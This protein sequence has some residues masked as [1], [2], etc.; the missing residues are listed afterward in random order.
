MG[1]KEGPFADDSGESETSETASAINRLRPTT[2]L[3]N[4]VTAAKISVTMKTRWVGVLILLLVC[5]DSSTHLL[6]SK[7]APA[8]YRIKTVVL[9][10]GHGGHDPGCHGSTAHEKHIALGIVLKLGKIL[11]AHYPDVKVIYTRD[12]DVFVELNERAAIANRNDADLFISVH[13]NSASSPS[14]YGTE[15]WVM[16]AKS[17][18]ANLEVAK[19]ENS[20]I[21]LEEDYAEKYEYDPNSPVGQIIFSVYQNAYLEQSLKLANKIETQ[22]KTVNN[23]SSRGVKRAGFIV[24]YR[25]YMPSVLIESGFLTNKSDESYLTSEK[26]QQEMAQSIFNAFREYKTEMEE[27]SPVENSSRGDTVLAPTRDST[28]AL[29]KT[30]GDQVVFKIQFVATPAQLDLSKSPYNKLSDITTESLANGITRY[31]TGSYLDPLEAQQ[32][33]PTVKASGFQDAFLVCYVNGVQKPFN[34]GKALMN[35]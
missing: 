18:E 22:F 30:T 5:F 21:M 35:R 20:V 9:D 24:L 28:S 4:F 3:D 33:L 23:R 16:A 6:V 15:T 1:T 25:T 10:A 13:C 34:Y 12:K 11:T 27:I 29:P 32:A 19:R 31:C 2:S 7:P 8:S 26:G 17:S 14:A